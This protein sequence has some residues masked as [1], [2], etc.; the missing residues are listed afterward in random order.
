MPSELSSPDL[1]DRLP[2]LDGVAFLLCQ[3]ATTA[4]DTTIYWSPAA[5]S[6][7]GY[8][9]LPADG[10]SAADLI[11]PEDR[12]RILASWVRVTEENAHQTFRILT[13][14]GRVRWLDTTLQPLP[15]PEGEPPAILGLLVDITDRLDATSDR[16]HFFN[17]SVDMLAISTP[18]GW[19]QR[20]N[21]A[22]ERTLGFPTDVLMARRARDW[23]HPDDL[24]T[25]Q[26]A[27]RAMTADEQ[28]RRFEIRLLTASG[29]WCWTA[30][31]TSWDGE[32]RLVHSVVRD[33]TEQK[34]AEQR[35]AALA[36]QDALTGLPNRVALLDHLARVLATSPDRP[37]ALLLLD[38]DGFKHVNDTYGH[39]LGDE[40]LQDFAHRLAGMHEEMLASSP[41]DTDPCS[42]PML[43]RLGGDE[44][45]VVL[46]DAGADEALVCAQKLMHVV[47]R[48]VLV[49]EQPVALGGSVGI[50]LAPAHGSSA[51]QLLR[52][53]DVAMY[54][55]KRAGSGVRIYQADLD[56]GGPERFSLQT[57]L[58][59]GILSEQL[60]LEF[61]PKVDLRS[62]QI[63][64]LEALVRWIHPT[65]GVMAPDSFIPLAE[66]SGLIRPLTEW[67]LRWS[68]ERCR[69]WLHAGA[70][71]AVA[72]NISPRSLRDPHLVEQVAAALASVD[73]PG[74]YL[75]L[76]V[77]ESLVATDPAQIQT[78]SE[79]SRLG[80]RLVIDDFGTGYSSLAS[81]KRLPVQQIKVDRSFVGEMRTS[82]SDK[83]IVRA[84]VDLGSSL[85][86]QVVA[87]GVEDAATL[88]ALAVMECDA[89]QG[90]FVT[91]P[92]PGRDIRQW[93]TD[94]A[95]A[96]AGERVLA[97]TRGVLPLA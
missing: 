36:R 32:R 42:R 41:D 86:L 74:R 64:A 55:A 68:L 73:L 4:A 85:G 30:W 53:A 44:F 17:Q 97:V 24:E 3:T 78:L 93:L 34:A 95:A 8:P 50:A 38:L 48:P 11:H 91:R 92:I 59:G 33:I 51:E 43:A 9:S 40:V 54:A 21:P 18:D 28:P 58:R 45:A 94:G 89:I 13:G 20:L 2:R 76:E 35:L 70:D 60:L 19:F 63:L 15:G 6:L 5:V 25:V 79:L 90:F 71:T 23:V 75:E 10:E 87:E 67:V 37:V 1:L 57:D 39:L 84:S 96:A 46:A 47:E 14:D 29:D 69:Q 31:N 88:E 65:R 81:L 77:T 7:F 62:G 27:V 72:V 82:L 49:Q 61:E 16:D 56:A 83:A 80:V 26:Q 12:E 66:G 22:W 52:A